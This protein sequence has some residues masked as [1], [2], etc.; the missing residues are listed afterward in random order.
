MTAEESNVR[1]GVS[2]REARYAEAIGRRITRHLPAVVRLAAQDVMAVAD[3]ELAGVWAGRHLEQQALANALPR[4]VALDEVRQLTVQWEREAEDL[5]QRG[6]D[7]FARGEQA[8]SIALCATSRAT[9]NGAALLRAAL[10]P[11]EAG[12]PEGGADRG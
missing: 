4:L 9:R 6:R 7:A 3:D 10:A 11:A 5:D 8:E 12:E 1:S 2:A